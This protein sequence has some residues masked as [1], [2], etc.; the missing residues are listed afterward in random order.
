MALGYLISP[1]LQ[2]ED[3]NGKPLTGGWLNVYLHGTLNHAFTYKDY[4][5]HLNPNDIALNDKGMAVIIASDSTTYD[6]YC[7]DRNG[8]EQWSRLN[9]CT[10]GSGSGGGGGGEEYYAGY[11]ILIDGANVISID[12]STVQGKLTTGGGVEIVNN[13]IG[14]K[15]DN[16]TIMI[17]VDGELEANFPQQVNA[18]WT[19]CMANSA[20][21]NLYLKIA[22]LNCYT[23][24]R[25]VGSG[26]SD[27][28]VRCTDAD[29]GRIYTVAVGVLQSGTGNHNFGCA[30]RPVLDYKRDSA[31]QP[32][33]SFYVFSD[34]AYGNDQ[35]Q[36]KLSLWVEFDALSYNAWTFEAVVNTAIG[37]TGDDEHENAW[38]FANSK[39]ATVSAL[40]T[41]GWQLNSKAPAIVA[42]PAVSS[43]DNGKMLVASYVG[44]VANYSWESVAVPVIGTITV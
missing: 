22:E 29:E 17:N 44:G 1:A 40:P 38:T 43:G 6:V 26:Y 8:V 19:M 16:S 18:G 39:R 30:L 34:T 11:G 21:S 10:I 31:S 32:I 14:L 36:A 41:G 13:E 2:L 7:Y 27:L 12:Q 28:I 42:V 4:S 3:I 5:A 37:G 33:K 35:S 20:T 25:Q 15:V 23:A 24:F 9:V